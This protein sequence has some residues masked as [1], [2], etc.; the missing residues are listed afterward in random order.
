MKKYANEVL[1]LASLIVTVGCGSGAS[2]EEPPNE[3]SQRAWQR[4][5]DVGRGRIS[6][7]QAFRGAVQG[8]ATPL[9]ADPLC[10]VPPTR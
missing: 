8:R 9:N 6:K 4:C 5:A 7:F 1:L 10:G 2:V 3:S